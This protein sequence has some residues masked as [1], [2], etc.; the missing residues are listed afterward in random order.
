MGRSVAELNARSPRAVL[1]WHDLIGAA[2]LCLLLGAVLAQGPA[3]KHASVLS[4]ARAGSPSSQGL[5]SLPLAAQAPVSGKLGAE[6]PAYR[7]RASGG[8][9]Q[10]V[11]RP[12]RL[13]IRF[14]R[15]GVVLGSGAL[16]L[17]LSLRAM[18]YGTS[19][20]SL[21]H[22]T[23]SAQA[24][25]VIY[26]QAGVSEWY[27]NGPLGLEQGFTVPRSPSAHPTGP[28]TLLMTLSGNAHASLSAGGQGITLGHAGAHP[29]RYGDLTATD[30]SGR[31]LRSWLALHA[32]KLL[33]HVDTTGAR[34]PVVIDPLIQQGEELKGSG[35]A[36]EGQFG[37]S[38]ALSA[39][40][41]TALIGAPN[42]S[43]VAGAVWVFTRSGSIWT[44]QGQKL[45]GREQGG[46]AEGQCVQEV[47]EESDRCG[48]GRSVALSADGNTAL[49]GGPRN[50][51]YLGAAWVFTRSGTT[52]SQQ[53]QLTGGEEVGAGHFGRSVA[54]SADGETALIGGGSDKGGH[55]AA[56]VFTRSGTAWTQQGEK[57][58]GGGESH[59]GYFGKSVA[60]SSDGNT[61]L[62]GGPGDARRAGAAWVFTRS[63]TTWTQQG[64]KLTGGGEEI[65]E[66]RFGFSV[67]LSGDASTALIGGRGDNGN[68]GAAW[69]F[70]QSGTSWTQQGEKLQGGAEESGAGEFGYSSALSSDGQTAL[71]G[72]PS[73]DGH[74]GAAWMFTRSGT[75]WTQQGSPSAGATEIGKSRFGTSVALSSDGGTMLVGG[76]YDKRRLGAVWTFLG[77]PPVPPPTVTSIAPTS[78]SSSG[79]TPVTIEGSG[80]LAG[81]TVKI[82]SAAASV[83]VVSA[84]EIKATTAPT[85]AGGDEVAVTDKNGTSTQGPLYTYL[86][87]PANAVPPVVPS[88]GGQAASSVTASSGVLAN[89][90][91]ALPAPTLGVTGNLAP[92]SGRVF[93]KLPGS[94]SFISLASA[95]QVPFGTIVDASHGRV[96]VTTASP[97]GGTQT[98]T[99][100]EG[101][102]ELT[103]GR[104]GLVVA[105]LKGGN[106]SVCPTARERS[107]LA[108]ASSKHASRKHA[109]RKL[110]A[111]GHGSYSTK[112]NYASGAVLGTRW[113]TED[114]CD[115]TLI[116]VATDRVAVTNLVNHRHITVKAGHS[117][118][119]KAP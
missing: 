47:N 105:T 28:M 26:A 66:G 103:Q 61:A 118:L 78:G 75:S 23:P 99:F 64:S 15:S 104:D 48:F 10:A 112:G 5:S 92:V 60:L 40:G 110:W 117:Y 54:L 27:L 89:V 106:F 113:L 30:A 115:G 62:I 119:A 14:D 111:E 81:A 85:E 2:L 13:H 52:W 6:S 7:V 71:I 65:G 4:G 39:D 21:G 25:R 1:R 58:R 3:V 45:T 97:H 43:S 93:V 53:A 34:F 41:S 94:S 76:A 32:G 59:V 67:A 70:T 17:G 87:A 29:L 16:R 22:V 98:M 11:S 116:R 86:T 90:A 24:N 51:G 35:E 109:V 79:G 88:G 8:W 100:F 72:G 57:L 33:L 56:W 55:G 91:V 96:S 42:E 12:Q 36:G 19:L 50:D 9:L 37:F 73:D 84:T 80:F 101:E 77:S 49:I 95:R 44:P 20:R 31:T 83:T 74:L 108:R 63:G 46:G 107:H 68:L 18:G 69:V 38:V 102:F 114:L 82:G